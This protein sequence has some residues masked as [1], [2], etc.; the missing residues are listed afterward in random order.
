[1]AKAVS[2]STNL[3]LSKGN[4]FEEEEE[5]ADDDADV[6]IIDFANSTHEGLRDSVCHSGPDQG[7]LFGLDTLIGIL[8][9]LIQGKVTREMDCSAQPVGDLTEALEIIS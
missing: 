2:S 5:V 6:R 4:R 8:E 1:M 7:F 9:D 3:L